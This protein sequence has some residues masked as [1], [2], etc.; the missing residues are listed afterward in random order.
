MLKKLANDVQN[1]HLGMGLKNN[2]DPKFH[3]EHLQD[4]SLASTMRHTVTKMT[5]L[6]VNLVISVGSELYFSNVP[7]GKTEGVQ[8]HAGQDITW[9]LFLM[10]VSKLFLEVKLLQGPWL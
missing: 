7:L 4:A 6:I 1:V 8:L 9:I 5:L 2:V 3:M 10:S